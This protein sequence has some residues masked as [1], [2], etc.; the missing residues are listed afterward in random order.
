V[1]ATLEVQEAMKRTDFLLV[2]V[3]AN[4]SA[5]D[6]SALAEAVKDLS[7]VALPGEDPKGDWAQ[8]SEI[9]LAQV[10]SQGLNEDVGQAIIIKKNGRVGMRSLGVPDWKSLTREVDART[11]L[12]LDTRNV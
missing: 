5:E 7:F 3:L 8:L 12:G 4:P 11:Q 2:P 10:R 9:Q 1:D 6:R